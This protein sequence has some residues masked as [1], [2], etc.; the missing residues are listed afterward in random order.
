PSS[1]PPTG[2]GACPVAGPVTFVDSWGAPRSGGRTHE[3]VD[4]IAARGTPIAAI[5]SG[6]IQ[7]ATTSSLGGIT[8]WLLSD[9]GDEYYYAHLDGYAAGIA[10]GVRVAE[11]EIIGFN[12]STGNA[13]DYLPHLH[14]EYHPGGGAPVNP[15]PLVATLCP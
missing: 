10:A 3:G 4:M 7:S 12:G 9:A 14:F 13:P 15:Y 2:G 5:Y 1:P 6:V 11:G 8:L